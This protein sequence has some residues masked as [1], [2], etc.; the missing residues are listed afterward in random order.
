MTDTPAET[1]AGAFPVGVSFAGAIP[2]IRL[3]I[4]G[5]DDELF[6]DLNIASTGEFNE[7]EFSSQATYWQDIGDSIDG[8]FALDSAIWGGS[9][10]YLEENFGAELEYVITLGET[11]FDTENS[12]PAIPPAPGQL[13]SSFDG[14]PELNQGVLDYPITISIRMGAEGPYDTLL[15]RALRIGAAIADADA[16]GIADE[17][18]TCMFS[19][20]SSTVTFRGLESGV[21]NYVGAD[22]CT[23]MDRYAACEPQEQERSSR[24]SRFQPRYSGPS[25]CEKQVSYG[26]FDEGIIDYAEARMLR[27]A[28]YMSY[29]SQSR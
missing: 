21:E 20:M 26:L 23:V 29:R 14:Y 6:S 13:F 19:D 15:G 4:F 7:V 1:G 28:L 18:D 8:L 11:F 22:G 3:K 17:L 12:P 2:Q 24:F 27:D 25:Y 10:V 16:D 5:P 9:G